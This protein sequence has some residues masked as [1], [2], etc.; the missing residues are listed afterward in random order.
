MPAILSI[1]YKNV[2]F[3]VSVLSGQE[4]SAKF[5]ST[6]MKPLFLFWPRQLHFIYI[7]EIL[8]I[9]NTLSEQEISTKIITSEHS[10]RYP[11]A[12]NCIYNGN[13]M[14]TLEG[15]SWTVSIYLSKARM[16]G[17]TWIIW[18]NSIFWCALAK[19]VNTV[20]SNVTHIYTWCA[21]MVS[22]LKGTQPNKQ[23]TAMYAWLSVQ[24]KLSLA[25]PI[26]TRK[27]LFLLLYID[28]HITESSMKIECFAAP[29][30]PRNI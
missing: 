8:A 3:L 7:R 9:G 10:L 2:F 26:T 19:L 12:L 23:C 20:S 15:F 1:T 25:T 22:L 6:Q 13:P 24:Y 21:M 17:Y 16:F 18:S 14:Y 4:M 28:K 29:K 27:V 30:L 5:R 11:I